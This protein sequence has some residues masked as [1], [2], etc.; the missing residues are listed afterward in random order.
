M[1][2]DEYVSGFGAA[3]QDVVGTALAFGVFPEWRYWLSATLSNADL[4]VTWKIR[5]I[6]ETV[7]L[8]RSPSSSADVVAEAITYHDITGV[9]SMDDKTTVRFGINNLTEENPPYFHSNFNANTEPGVWDVI[10]RRIF[11][12]LEYQF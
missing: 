6:D 9:W 12:G 5:H 4:S 11:V 1:L 7:D 3:S 10:G 2:H 8:Y